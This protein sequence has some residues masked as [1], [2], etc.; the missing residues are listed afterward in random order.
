MGTDLSKVPWLMLPYQ[1]YSSS[2]F[3][4]GKIDCEVAASDKI[5][6]VDLIPVH[7]RGT[8]KLGRN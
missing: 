4:T 1:M 7:L 2:V 6:G 8:V 5:A 3:F